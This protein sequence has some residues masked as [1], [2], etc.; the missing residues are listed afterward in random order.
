MSR[1]PVGSYG[2]AA[3]RAWRPLGRRLTNT[4]DN[5]QGGDELAP[6]HRFLLAAASYASDR[7]FEMHGVR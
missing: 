4:S 7:H 5:P 3:E 6:V 1:Q 2:S